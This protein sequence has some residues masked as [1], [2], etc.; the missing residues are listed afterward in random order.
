MEPLLTREQIR[1]V[2]QYAIQQLG[3]PE[4]L[5]M[6]HAAIAVADAIS[7]RFGSSLAFSK[8]LVLA[9]PGNN[10]AD[11]LASVRILEER[12]CQQIFVVLV[13]DDPAKK[14]APL[15]DIQLSILGKLGIASGVEL[16]RELLE[17]CD[18]VIDGIYGTGLKQNLSGK[19]LEAVQ[20]VNQFA[21]KK[22]VVSVDIPSGL[23]SDTGKVMGAAVQA[24]E[25]V[26]LG[27]LKRGLV[28]AHSADYV[29]KIRLATI[30]IPRMVPLVVDAFWYTQ[31]D[32]SRLPLRKKSSHKGDF[33]H[34][35]VVAGEA[36]KEGACVLT[37]LGALKTGAGLVSLLGSAEELSRLKP[38]LPVEV[39]TE[40]LTLEFFKQTP[41]GSIVMGPGLGVQH[42]EKVRACLASQWP[43]VLD[44]DA[45][46]LLAQHQKELLPLFK[47]RKN[48]ATVL[49]PHPKEAARLLGTTVEEVEND[50]FQAVQQLAEKYQSYVLLKGKGT[51]I[52][53]PQGPTFVITQGDSGLA[54]GGSGDLLSGILG[55]LLLQG[56][57]H[58]QALLLGAYLHG[59]ASELLTQKTGTNR[60]SLPSEIAGQLT[61]A[62]SELENENLHSR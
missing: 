10:G 36:D 40:Q 28:T 7:N 60:A 15:V 59:R 23:N 20:L 13:H 53:G 3:I 52:R 45:L 48:T 14:A 32:V 25:T 46:T 39:M 47:N 35:W 62:L 37:A 6:E 34:V 29:G 5:L 44:A 21:G 12:G 1:S 42:F 27:F 49:T 38:R 8:G 24:N 55:T 2:D 41:R 43:V 17:A 56:L 11:A 19:S 26:T 33:G 4:L 22:W 57:S 18:W 31:A 58:Q 61:T 54:K 50:R 51:C 30:Q 9:G 16:T